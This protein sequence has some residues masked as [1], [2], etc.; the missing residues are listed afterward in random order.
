MVD[1]GRMPHVGWQRRCHSYGDILNAHIKSFLNVRAD[2][3]S[4]SVFI[5]RFNNLMS[6]AQMS[7]DFTGAHVRQL[8]TSFVFLQSIPTHLHRELMAFVSQQRRQ[9]DPEADAAVNLLE[10]PVDVLLDSLRAR[11]GPDARISAPPGD[12]QAPSVKPIVKSHERPWSK[13]TPS[14]IITFH[15]VPF[16]LSRQICCAASDFRAYLGGRQ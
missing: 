3:E 15:S 8:L 2:H 10:V 11:L 4:T 9:A 12:P 14:S 5:H 7:D 6:K 16:H 13:K 1:R